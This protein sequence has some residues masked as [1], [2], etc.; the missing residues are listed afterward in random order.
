MPSHH[1]P[2]WYLACRAKIAQL[3]R[4]LKNH[5]KAAELEAD[6]RKMDLDASEAANAAKAADL[7]QVTVNYQALWADRNQQAA[8]RRLCEQSIAQKDADLQLK[9]ARISAKDARIARLEAIRSRQERELAFI[10]AS[11]EHGDRGEKLV[12]INIG[13]GEGGLEIPGI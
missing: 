3:E 10:H 11:S 5:E 8:M 6:V 1:R 9:D 12:N 4:K 13:S 2:E 7:A